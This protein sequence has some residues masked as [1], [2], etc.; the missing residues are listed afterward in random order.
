MKQIIL[1]LILLYVL[2]PVDCCPGPVD[3]L[4]ICLAALAAYG[5]SKD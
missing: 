2:S 3:D 5:S 4:I 1:I